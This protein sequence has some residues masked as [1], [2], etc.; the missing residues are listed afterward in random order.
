MLGFS[1]IIL[2]Q[3]V[4]KDTSWIVTQSVDSGSLYFGGTMDPDNT[5]YIGD[6]FHRT[7]GVES[8]RYLTITNLDSVPSQGAK[9]LLNRRG[10]WYSRLEMAE[11]ALNGAVTEKEKSLSLFEFVRRNRV[12][13]YSAEEGALDETHEPVKLMGVYGFG[14]CDDAAFALVNLAH[15][16]NIPAIEWGITAHNIAEIAFNNPAVVDADLEVFYPGYDNSSL[17]G[18]FGLSD[19]RY[20]VSRILH[21]GQNIPYDLGFSKHLASMFTTFDG[22][23]HRNPSPHQ[24]YYTLLPEQSVTFS[25]ARPDSLFEHR[26]WRDP[27]TPQMFNRLI[28]NALWNHA[29]N[30]FSPG[31]R[32]QFQSESNL[33]VDTSGT[34]IRMRPLNPGLA[35]EL[36]HKV[37]LP[38]PQLDHKL[39]YTA[40]LP[41]SQD[42]LQVEWSLD[43]LSWTPAYFKSGPF[44]GTDSC[45]LYQ[46]ILPLVNAAIYTGWIRISVVQANALV[47]AGLDSLHIQTRTQ[48]S[49]FFLPYLKTGTNF[50][51][52][53]RKDSLSGPH[54]IELGWQESY[55]NNPPIISNVPVY[56]GMGITTDTAQILFRWGNAQDPDGDYPQKYQFQLS[57]RPDMAFCLASNFDRIINPIPPGNMAF[58]SFK[59]EVPGFLNHGQTYYWRVRAMDSQGLWGPW[60]NTWSFTVNCVMA[61][62]LSALTLNDSNMVISWNPGSPG[63]TPV[64]YAVHGSAEMNGFTPS[65]QTF[66]GLTQDTFWVFD[67]HQGIPPTFIR[68]IAL[69][70]NGE[71]SQPSTVINSPFP[72]VFTHSSPKIYPDSVFTLPLKSNYRYYPFYFYMYPDTIPHTAWVSPISFPTALNWNSTLSE[73]AATPDSATVR[74]M[75]YDLSLRTVSFQVIAPYSQPVHQ[76]LILQPGLDNNKPLLDSYSPVVALNSPLQD[77]LFL[78]EGDAAFGDTHTWHIL[79]SPSWISTQTSHEYII[80]SGTPTYASI[81]DPHLE[82]IV[83]DSY[84]LQ[85]TLI[86]DFNFMINNTAPLILSY[87]DTLV[88][89]NNVYEYP[90]LVYDP[91]TLLGDSVQLSIQQGPGW[92]Y[93]NSVQQKL[94][95]YPMVSMVADSLVR[96][97][98]TDLAGSWVEQE[99]ILHF[100]RRTDIDPI[101]SS[102]S[103]I[104]DELI[105]DWT[106]E[107]G[108]GIVLYPNPAN[109]L[110][111]M[112]FKLPKNGHIQVELHSAEGRLIKEL[113]SDY[114]EQGIRQ[115][116]LNVSNLPSGLYW[117]KFQYRT[118]E[119]SEFYYTQKL[120]VQP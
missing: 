23:V 116:P 18:K 117:V 34:G 7:Y 24:L 76:T 66:I 72:F 22:V 9:F 25:W 52:F 33:L 13:Y 92:L 26:I 49:K 85:D 64:A 27:T 100:K 51:Q 30:P 114:R 80:I 31:F 50:F 87:P 90:V 63:K 38:F 88:D 67:Y 59:P 32:Y 93:L 73:F 17:M 103:S 106:E 54:K 47:S 35:L 119:G 21:H 41:S 94:Q 95:G 29:V 75:L 74:R 112:K 89:P 120:V 110:T 78:L 107:D 58:P 48:N 68:I 45:S 12:H 77:T 96:I 118:E 8:M 79:N 99:F 69:D 97:R 115:I 42:S 84:G 82:L 16:A 81:Q 91:D 39:V 53:S 36:V 70:S 3:G 10:N 20:L 61:P 98:A 109:Y 19:D 43:S 4:W 105:G 37:D 101:D 1:G 40:I 102:G 86:Y 11:E 108:E 28:A 15:T 55:H 56:P 2:A 6:N 83:E 71:E 60:T 5:R 113:L 65:P 104:P 44:T 57:D 62:S 111:Y 14:L 46:Q